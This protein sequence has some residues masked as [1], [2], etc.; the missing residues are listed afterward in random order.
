M[1]SSDVYSDAYRHFFLSSLSFVIAF[2]LRDVVDSSIDTLLINRVKYKNLVRLA[3]IL[4]MIAITAAI[5]QT[6]PNHQTFTL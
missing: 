2:S 5:V 6:W 1:S 3:W 4:I